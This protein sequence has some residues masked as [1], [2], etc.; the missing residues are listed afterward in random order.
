MDKAYIDFAALYSMHRAGSFFVTRA[1]VT[2]SYE[3]LEYNYYIDEWTGH[4]CDK[5]IKL[6]GP[7]SKQLYAEILRIVGYYDNKKDLINL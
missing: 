7:K 3:D 2:L 6:T 4:R 5:T 1:K